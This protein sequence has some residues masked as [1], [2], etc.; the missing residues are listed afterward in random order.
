MTDV[1]WS[2]HGI[3]TNVI[4]VWPTVKVQMS[5]QKE[6]ESLEARALIRRQEKAHQDPESLMGPHNKENN[7]SS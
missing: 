6:E 5:K 7:L 4:T 3:G 2:K 1:Q